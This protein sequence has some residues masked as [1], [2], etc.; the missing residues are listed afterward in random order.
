MS[1][2]F[3]SCLV[4]NAQAILLV[5]LGHCEEAI[6]C[7]KEALQLLQPN[8]RLPA[9]TQ[10]QDNGNTKRPY[11]SIPVLP[12][13]IMHTSSMLS[14]DNIFSFY[15]RMFNITEH[16]D[17]K[18]GAA[19][20]FVI[21]IFNL[22][23]AH[24]VHAALLECED[25]ANNGWLKLETPRDRQTRL[26]AIL[27]MYQN[28]IVGARTTLSPD[29]VGGLLCVVTAAANNAGHLN[30]CMNNFQEMQAS[31]NL[32]M[33]LMKLSYGACTIPAMDY[34]I[35]FSSIFVFLEGAGLS[36]SPAA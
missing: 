14:S 8:L 6:R 23:M 34:G 31:L 3:E 36:I 12:E 7:I 17:S 2:T 28:V 10:P 18:F 35:F 26:T 22:A 11:Y 25:N 24:H 16:D 4:L 29:E 32:E 13:G 20:I 19:K 33:Q 30:T 9:A 1:N 15:P 27:K 21:L 5:Q